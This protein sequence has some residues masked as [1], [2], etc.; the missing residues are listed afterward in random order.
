MN[1]YEKITN[2]T[3]KQV[4]KLTLL[5]QRDIVRIYD[6][7]IKSISEQVKKAGNKTLSK[8]WLIDYRKELGSTRA[9]L[10]RALGKSITGYT[11][12]AADKSIEGQAKILGIILNEAALDTGNHFS[13]AF[14]V[15][16]KDVIADIISGG[17]YKDKRGLSSR[18]WIYTKDNKKDVESIIL[19]GIAE[20]KSAI[21]IAEDLQEFV[22]PKAQRSTTWGK[23]YPMLM[24]KII[25]YNAMR[26]ARTSINHAYQTATIRS[27]NM[28]PFVDGILWRSAAIHGRTCDVCMDRDGQI[29]PKNDVPLDHPNGLCTMIP[30]ITKS[31]D[32]VAEE[33]YDCVYGEYNPKLD[34]W[35]KEFGEY[36]INKT[37]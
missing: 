12:L 30:Y 22:K 5:Q 1:E 9:E 7:A 37:I 14:S 34:E 35:Y 33:L 16:Q 17:L 26:L 32:E 21:K 10:A 18:I 3:R 28:N 23:A 6:E 11:T 19:Q 2:E 36:F 25:D 8:R 4:S 20:K 27:S 31:T 29:F 24:G 13:T 15:V